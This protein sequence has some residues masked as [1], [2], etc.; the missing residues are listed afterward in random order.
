MGV[1]STRFPPTVTSDRD[2]L[3]PGGPIPSA[4][5]AP[6]LKDEGVT[7]VIFAGDPFFPIYLT[8]AA[9]NQDYFPEWIV[10][11]S[12][13]TDST[14]FARRYDQQ[15]WSHAFGLSFLLARVDPDVVDEAGNWVSWYLG[16]TL[17]QYP[18]IFDFGRLFAGIHLAGP[19]LTPE[20]FRDGLYRYPVSGGGPTEVQVSRGDHGVWPDHDWGGSDDM[21]II[22]FD[23]EAT[24]EDE[25]GNEGTGMYR[26]ANGGQRETI[27]NLPRSPGEAGPF[28]PGGPATVYDEVPDEDRAPDYPPPG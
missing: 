15:Q 5:T 10:T 6:R 12:T 1:D 25:V 8:E 28:D 23:P 4:T 22:W 9:T 19:E 24:G 17:E 11:G 3:C 2:R 13:G 27:G 21:A 18:N 16:E 20:A 26:Y 7:S 14:A